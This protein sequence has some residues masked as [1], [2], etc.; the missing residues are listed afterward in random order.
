MTLDIV[1]AAAMAIR[2]HPEQLNGKP[3]ISNL[4]KAIDDLETELNK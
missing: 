4:L 1:R 3:N 2:E